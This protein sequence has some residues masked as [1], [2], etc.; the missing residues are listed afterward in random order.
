MVPKG[1]PLP[2]TGVRNIH[3]PHYENCLDY[4]VQERWDAWNC[5]QCPYRF[6]QQPV[7]VSDYDVGGDGLD[8]D[9]LCDLPQEVDRDL[10]A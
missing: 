6:L 4:A 10:F 5:A 3:C 2:A 9:L 1:N 8:Y 7:D